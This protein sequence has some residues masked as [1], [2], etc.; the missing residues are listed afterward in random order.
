MIKLTFKYLKDWKVR[1]DKFNKIYH[2]EVSLEWF[3]TRNP[4]LQEDI[5]LSEFL[6]NLDSIYTC[7]VERNFEDKFLVYYPWKRYINFT[8]QK[9]TIEKYWNYFKKCGF[10]FWPK[11]DIVYLGWSILSALA[12][13]GLD[14]KYKGKVRV[15]WEFWSISTTKTCIGKIT[16]V[17]ILGDI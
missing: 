14:E 15:H 9:N 16:K 3:L 4:L 8:V 1:S 10:S 2:N 11:A 5:E 12:T 13:E 6:D 17:D 7:L